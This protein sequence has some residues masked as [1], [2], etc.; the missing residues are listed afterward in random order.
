MISDDFP[1]FLR[2]VLEDDHVPTTGF[3]CEVIAAVTF[4][5]IWAK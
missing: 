3:Y 5:D 1:S 4:P 2:L